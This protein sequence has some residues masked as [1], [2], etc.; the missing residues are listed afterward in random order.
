MY[1]RP[2][3][4]TLSAAKGLPLAREIL[5]FAQNDKVW[6]LFLVTSWALLVAVPV[7][8]DTNVATSLIPFD[9][10][11]VTN[12][13]LVRSVTDHYT[14]RREYAARQFKARTEHFEYLIDHMEACS[15]LA[16]KLGLIQ[17][18]ATR[19]PEGRVFADDHEGARGY[20][21]PVLAAE[22]K[23]VYYVEGSQRGL[24]DVTGRGV[25]VIDYAQVNP[26]KIK[27]TG[28]LFVK[29]DNMIL[30]ALARLFAVF[31]RGTLDRHYNHV[32]RHPRKLSEMALIEPQ[33]LLNHI[34]QMSEQDRKLLQPFAEMLRSGANQR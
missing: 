11:T 22:G 31:L 5:R 29:V 14:L 12:R 19:D 3:V 8:A 30:E 25:A 7:L 13:M 34:S 20:L 24:F 23:R 26:H 9:A 10:M 2:S 1:V 6:R 28:A 32:M 15:V 33:K 17:Y 16:Q 27:Y 21:W 18:R 4:V